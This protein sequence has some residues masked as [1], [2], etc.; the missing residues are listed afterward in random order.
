MTVFDAGI[1]AMTDAVKAAGAE[2]RGIKRV[3]LG[4]DDADHRGA[5]A[6]LS[7]LLRESDRLALCSDCICTLDVQT[8]IPGRA[9]V[10]HPAYNMD[11]DQAR[12]SI[13]KLTECEP[14]VV[15]TGPSHPV[16]GDVRSQLERAAAV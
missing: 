12:A 14:A 13:R 16:R 9:R 7:A 11:T 1:V 3:A 8:G 6:G 2:L 10:P 15:W 5:A 4:H